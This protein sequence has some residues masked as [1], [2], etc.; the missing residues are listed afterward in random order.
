MSDLKQLFSA[1]K[2]NKIAV[3]GLGKETERV[4]TELLPEFQIIGLLDGD[5]QEGKF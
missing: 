5:K 4:L 2:K 1:Y 3:Y